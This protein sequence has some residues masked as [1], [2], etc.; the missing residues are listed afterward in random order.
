MA[1]VLIILGMLLQTNNH[2][3][4]EREVT[5]SL[6][7]PLGMEDDYLKKKKKDII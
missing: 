1:L 2:S 4:P 6:N 3:V 7:F 5:K